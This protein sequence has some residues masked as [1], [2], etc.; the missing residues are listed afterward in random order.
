MWITLGAE[1]KVEGHMIMPVDL[2]EPEG[3]CN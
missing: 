2:G 1:K 3:E